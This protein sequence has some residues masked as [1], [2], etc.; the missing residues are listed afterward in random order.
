MVCGGNTS[1]RRRGGTGVVLLYQAENPELTKWKFLGKLFECRDAEVINLECPNL[2]PLGGKWVL[3]DSPHK[4]CQYFVGTVDFEKVRF[5]PETRGV[6]D[7][8][9]A[10]ASNISVDEKGRT[11]LWLWGR[12]DNPEATGWNGVM[13]LPRVL[14]LG[15]DGFLRQQPAAEFEQLRGAEVSAQPVTLGAKPAALSGIGGDCLEFE[16]TYRGGGESDLALEL[17]RS[18]AGKAGAMV[19]ITRDGM[20]RVN[21]ASTLIGQAP[22]YRL[23]IFLDKRV[24]EVYVN[25]GQAAVYAIAGAQKSDTGVAAYARGRE[26]QLSA[27]RAWPLKPAVFSMEYFRV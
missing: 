11:I 1:G 7:A 5:E 18:D 9:N 17:R 14:S 13:V 15:N 19:G 21:G 4:P 26:S 8:G 24:F 20:L 10:Y 3:I 6:L 23:R 27:I 25:E 22:E 16:C 12:T 2:F